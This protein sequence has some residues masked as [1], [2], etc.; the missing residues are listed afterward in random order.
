MNIAGDGRQRGVILAMSDSA[1]AANSGV[2]L[3]AEVTVKTMITAKIKMAAALLYAATVL[4]A[5]DAIPA[6]RLAATLPAPSPA[7]KQPP[8]SAPTRLSAAAA[9]R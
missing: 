6:D 3:R 2:F 7:A 1:G 4:V 8:R 5:G 9:D